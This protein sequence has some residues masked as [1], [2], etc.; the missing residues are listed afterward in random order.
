MIGRMTSYLVVNGIMGDEERDVYSY[1]LH[2]R[3][4]GG[5]YHAKTGLR[6][7]FFPVTLIIVSLLL[8][9]SVSTTKLI[10]FIER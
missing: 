2:L 10:I 4:Y 7:Y 3:I 8:I 9:K 5:S 6:C 1:G